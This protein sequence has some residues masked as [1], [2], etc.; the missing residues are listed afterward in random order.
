MARW[1]GGGGARWPGVA[2]TW[3]CGSRIFRCPPRSCAVGKVETWGNVEGRGGGGGGGD[4]GGGR[5]GGGEREMWRRVEEPQPWW[6]E[7][8]LEL[9]SQPCR[10]R[11]AWPPHPRHAAGGILASH[12]PAPA[13]AP[14]LPQAGA[15]PRFLIPRAR[16]HL[17]PR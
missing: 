7:P 14:P 6:P 3:T 10:T 8:L 5:G 11:P 2:S 12:A 9:T 1:R 15:Q 17:V 4:E 13:P 16:G